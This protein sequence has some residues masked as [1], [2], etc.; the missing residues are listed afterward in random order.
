MII[1]YA[2]P[3]VRC[4]GISSFAG[5]ELGSR[6]E[7]RARPCSIILLQKRSLERLGYISRPIISADLNERAQNVGVPFAHPPE[8][9]VGAPITNRFSWSCVRPYESTTLVLGSSPI[10]HPPPGCSIL[11]DTWVDITEPSPAAAIRSKS[12][13]N[14]S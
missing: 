9:I 6:I 3:N 2:M 4:F 5:T 8:T 14:V 7:V 10:R 12:R 13:N 1:C 11:V